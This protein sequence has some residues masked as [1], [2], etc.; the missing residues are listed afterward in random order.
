MPASGTLAHSSVKVLSHLD[1]PCRKASTCE[2]PCPCGFYGDDRKQCT[3]SMGL[4]QRYQKRISGPLMDRI[5]IHLEV[6]RVPC[7]SWMAGQLD[8]S[9]SGDGPI[10]EPSCVDRAGPITSGAATDGLRFLAEQVIYGA[11]FGMCFLQIIL[12]KRQVLTKNGDVRM[13]HKSRENIDVHAVSQT[14]QGK[15]APEC[16]R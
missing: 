1:E 6:V 16:M 7:P 4:V 13:A 14:P 9:T 10:R 3:C 11:K 5:D 2:N 8:D 12:D 15:S